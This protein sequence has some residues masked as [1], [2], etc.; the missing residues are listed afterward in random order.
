MESMLQLTL[1][2]INAHTSA[3]AGYVADCT[4]LAGTFKEQDLDRE[5][6]NIQEMRKFLIRNTNLND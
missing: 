1:I 5:Q 2:Y 4:W 6:G 3:A